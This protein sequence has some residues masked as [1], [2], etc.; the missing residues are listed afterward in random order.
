MFLRGFSWATADRDGRPRFVRKWDP[1]GP[2]FPKALTMILNRLSSSN[3]PCTY[4]GFNVSCVPRGLPGAYDD[5]FLNGGKGHFKEAAEDR[6]IDPNSL[7]GMSMV[8]SGRFR[9]TPRSLPIR[10]LIDEER[11]LRRDAAK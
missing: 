2:P 5:L 1:P 11:G 10:L 9:N 3:V 8:V 7:Y 4:S 6:D